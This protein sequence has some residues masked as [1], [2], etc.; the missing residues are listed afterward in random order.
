MVYVVLLSCSSKL[1]T[2]GVTGT[3]KSIVKS[4]KSVVGLGSNGIWTTEPLTGGNYMNS[5]GVN[6][7]VINIRVELSIPSWGRNGTVY[8]LTK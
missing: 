7:W 8:S 4:V 6:L 1:L 3:P 2:Q 5:C